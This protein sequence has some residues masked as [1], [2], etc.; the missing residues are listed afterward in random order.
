MSGQ[1]PPKTS[2]PGQ[3]PPRTKAFPINAPRLTGSFTNFHT[4]TSV[5]QTAVTPVIRV[6][7]MFVLLHCSVLQIQALLVTPLTC[8]G[9]VDRPKKYVKTNGEDLIYA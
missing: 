4:D 1:T 3:M 5:S 2:A 7:I 6:Y 8:R 9:V